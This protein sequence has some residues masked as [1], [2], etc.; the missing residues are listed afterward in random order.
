MASPIERYAAAAKA[1]GVP[2]GQLAN[3][4]RG[5]YVAQPHQLVWHAVA[6]QADKP[7][8]P[9][10]IGIGGRRGPGKTHAI[11]AQVALD[12]CQ[13]QPGLKVLFLRKFLKAAKE[14]FDGVRRRV[15]QGTKHTFKVVPGIIEFENGSQIY[16]GH[17]RTENEIDTYLGQ[18]YDAYVLEEATQFS[19]AKIDLLGGSLRTSKDWRTRWYLTTNT[20]G[21]GHAWFKRRI[22][23]PYY[24]GTQ[25]ET[26]FL[27]ANAAENIYNDEDYHKYLASLTGDL[28]RMWR[29]GDWDIYAG[30]YFSTFQRDIHVFPNKHNP[31]TLDTIPRGWRVWG[32]LDY[33]F[34]HYNTFHLFTE[35]DGDVYILDEHGRREWQPQM[36]IDAIVELLARYGLS[37]QHLDVVVAGSDINRRESSGNTVAQQYISAGF[38]IQPAND[39]RIDGATNF[40]SG[41]GDR[42]NGVAPWLFISH[43]CRN[44]IETLPVLEHDDHDNLK[45]KKWDTDDKGN[46]GDDWYDSARKG[47]LA[48][49]APGSNAILIQPRY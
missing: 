20:G 37:P 31:L 7:N 49:T 6:R 39:D 8:G 10:Y 17:F 32:S 24:N 45:V 21:V 40:L 2:Q 23:D 18:E 26:A 47:V 44:L 22:V 41:L 4:L 15:L 29:D 25:T 1:A 28:G 5:G 16:L 27:P 46:G 48:R 43:R 11:F 19:E 42:D 30:Q 13:R 12:D 35:N 34:R 14:S 3:F 36:H 9:K 38:N 33:G